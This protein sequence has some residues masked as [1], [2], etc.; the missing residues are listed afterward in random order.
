MDIRTLEKIQKIESQCVNPQDAVII[1]L[2]LE[3]IEANELVNIKSEALD[4]KNQLLTV[5]DSS[6][7]KRQ[8]P[9]TKRC[10]EI[11]QSAVLQTNY[12]I[13]NGSSTNKPISVH[14]RNSDHLIKVSLEDFVANQSMIRE[15]ESVVLRTIYMRLRRLSELFR[16]PELTHLTTEKFESK[17]LVYA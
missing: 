16:T 12:V 17:E 2:L 6:G 4:I 7:M 13:H 15:L 10:A 5:L 9:V 11:F 1:R 3:G 8:V 14:L